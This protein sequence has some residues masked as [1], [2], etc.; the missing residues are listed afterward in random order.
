MIHYV[1]MRWRQ[2]VPIM[3]TAT[4]VFNYNSVGVA[5]FKILTFTVNN[6]NLYFIIYLLTY[7][8][9]MKPINT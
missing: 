1:V 2:K 5:G 4:R 7:Y 3:S 6:T 8:I 9:Y